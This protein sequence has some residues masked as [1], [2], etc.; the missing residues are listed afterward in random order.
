MRLKAVHFF[1]S[2][3]CVFFNCCS[4]TE[5]SGSLDTK[6]YS[7][8]SSELD[9]KIKQNDIQ[10]LSQFKNYVRIDPGEFTMGSPQGEPGRGEDENPHKVVL[11]KP[12]WIGKFEVTKREWNQNLPFSLKRGHPVFS[13]KSR[14]IQ[15]LC[16]E[17]EFIDGN[18]TIREYEKVT[19]N[20]KIQKSFFLEESYPNFGTIGNWAIGGKN[21]KSYAI[22]SKKFSSL[23]EITK[24]FAQNKIS[25]IG[26]I[27]QMN[28][29]TH[30]SYSQA[31][32][33]CWNKSTLAHSLGKLPKGM[34]FRL[35]TEAEWEYVCR[36]GTLGFSGLGSGE[37]LSGVN[38]CLNGSRPEYVLGGEPMLINRKVVSPINPNS[39]RYPPNAWGVYDM[40]GNVMEWCQ[41]FYGQYSSK[42]AV[43]NPL[44]PFNGS[45]RVVRGGS[46][47]RTAHDCRSASRMSYEPSYRGSEIGFRMVIGYPVL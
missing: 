27:G 18:Y 45:R 3:S 24:Y 47:Y 7:P 30:I 32:A 25:A 40:H 44:G 42:S 37:R 15:K 11:T 23:S 26:R 41:D 12:F 13:L 4:E 1:F 14:T 2:V 43:I 22:N 10:K 39:P 8:F 35:P 34:F 29:I 21:R 17:G 9:L 20:G 28:P 36:A 16:K 19:S 38:A 5:V 31:T 6:P 46:F 33:F